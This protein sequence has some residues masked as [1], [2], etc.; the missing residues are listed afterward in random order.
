VGEL[1]E[2][3]QPIADLVGPSAVRAVY[4]KYTLGS[5]GNYRPGWEVRVETVF[6]GARLKL[7]NRASSLTDAARATHNQLKE[8]LGLN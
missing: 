3:L 1:L 7:S 8:A 6:Q 5:P 2:P 4:G